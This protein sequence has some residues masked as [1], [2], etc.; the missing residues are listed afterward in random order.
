MEQT[1]F[2]TW[3]IITGIA[4]FLIGLGSFIFSIGY[5][6]SKLK[7]KP[8][9]KEVDELILEKVKS[10]SENCSY[11]ENTDG[12]KLMQKVD[13]LDKKVNCIDGKVTDIYKLLI[14][15]KD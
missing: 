4:T 15:N 6:Y 10:H 12:S 1:L 8:G 3:G 11:F 14:K 7:D 9:R 5:N 13:D 2:P